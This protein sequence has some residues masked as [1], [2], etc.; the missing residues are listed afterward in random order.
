MGEP[1]S[2]A[3]VVADGG[4]DVGGGG[5]EAD[6]PQLATVTVAVEIDTCRRLELHPE[7]RT[8]VRVVNAP[9]GDKHVMAT[10]N[11]LR[12]YVVLEVSG[13]ALSNEFS[14]ERVL[15]AI[16][17]SDGRT[18]DSALE[19]LLQEPGFPGTPVEKKRQEVDN[20]LFEPQRLETELS[21][22]TLISHLFIK[23]GRHRVVRDLGKAPAGLCLYF[24]HP[25]WGLYE[26]GALLQLPWRSLVQLDLSHNNLSD[27]GA[28]LSRFEHLTELRLEDNR[29]EKVELHH[30]PR[31]RALYLAFNQIKLLPELLGLTALQYFDLGDNLIGSHKS[32][33]V[34]ARARA[35]ARARETAT[36]KP[37]PRPRPQN[38][39]RKTATAKP[40]PQPPAIARGLPAAPPRQPCT[41]HM[42]MAHAHGTCTWHMA[43]G[44]W[45]MAHGTCTGAD[46]RARRVSG[47]VGAAGALAAAGAEDAAAAEQ[48]AGVVAVGVQ[49]ARR[50]PLRQ[51]RPHRARLSR[52]PDVLQA[53]S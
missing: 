36:T 33:E 12:G 31:L 21:T 45:H 25:K 26:L 47:R 30:M 28:D 50:R 41:W 34:P 2:A 3:L 51:A 18:D 7:N 29:L 35:R 8:L 48:Q 11:E 10:L 5:G 49:H 6:E 52:Q 9:T 14:L 1:S 46:G 40:Q 15:D 38:R 39:D 23:K 4:G 17:R 53:A 43:H 16:E 19:L 42:H 24:N 37:R 32:G 13:V 22:D 20:N 27:V 44:T